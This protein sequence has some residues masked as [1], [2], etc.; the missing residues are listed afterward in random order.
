M[1]VG[2]RDLRL[3]YVCL[4]NV[5]RIP[6]GASETVAGVAGWCGKVCC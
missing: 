5:S 3:F 1:K 6:S 2:E 4:L